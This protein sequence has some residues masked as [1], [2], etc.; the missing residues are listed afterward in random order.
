MQYPKVNF[1]S[2]TL[3]IKFWWYEWR[4]VRGLRAQIERAKEIAALFGRHGSR[5]NG[6]ITKWENELKDKI[7]QEARAYSKARAALESV[8]DETTDDFRRWCEWT[9]KG[10]RNTPEDFT[11]ALEMLQARIAEEVA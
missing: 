5:L 4:R 7:E 1:S 8:T 6:I 10:I 2:E 3:D 11:A 9:F